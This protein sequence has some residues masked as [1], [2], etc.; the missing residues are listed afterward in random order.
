[1]PSNSTTSL[2]PPKVKP[3]KS[4]KSVHFSSETCEWATPTDFYEEA[5]KAYGPFRLDPCC[6]AENQ[7]CLY[8][9]HKNGLNQDW[10]FQPGMKVFMNPPYGREIGKWVKK[11]YEESLKG[12]F[13][14]CLLPSRTDTRWFHGYCARGRV[15]FLQGRLKFGGAKSSAPFPSMVVIFEPKTPTWVPLPVKE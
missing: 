15:I 4:R 11:A 8:G 3:R 6:N 9:F 10:N 5:N 7:K 14:F 13:V 2:A 1:M 12:A